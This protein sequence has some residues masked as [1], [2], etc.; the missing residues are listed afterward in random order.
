[1]IVPE[2]RFLGGVRRGGGQERRGCQKCANDLC[3]HGRLLSHPLVAGVLAVVE[4]ST[5]AQLPWIELWQFMQERP[6]ERL[7]G[8][9][10]VKPVF[11]S[12]AVPGCRDQSWHSWHR[13]GSFLTSRLRWR[14]PCGVWQ[15]VQSSVTGVCSQMNGPRLSAWQSCTAR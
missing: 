5:G 10:P 2:L 6:K 1:V 14:L 11:A 7:D 13:F 4:K 15:I 12:Y 9:V 8:D 3:L